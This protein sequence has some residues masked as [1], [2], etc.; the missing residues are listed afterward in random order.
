MLAAAGLIALYLQPQTAPSQPVATPSLAQS[1]LSMTAPTQVN[2]TSTYQS[3]VVINTGGNKAIAAQI[4]LNYNSSDISVSDITPGPFFKSPD[5]LFKKIDSANDR[6]SYALGAGLGQKGVQ[7]T[8]VVAVLTF[9]KL[10]TTGTTTIGFN[11]KSLVSA[12]GIAKSVLSRTTG[13]TFSLSS[14]SA[15]PATGT[16]SAK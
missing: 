4:E 16:S 15:T 8:G 9:T 14:P 1:T 11:P 2:G 5:E 10:K 12:E 3:N 13:V 7:G 6:V